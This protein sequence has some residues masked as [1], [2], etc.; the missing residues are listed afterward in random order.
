MC[1]QDFSD[2]GTTAVRQ[3]R[4][5]LHSF[6]F[7]QEWDIQYFLVRMTHYYSD[8]SVMDPKGR[9]NMVIFAKL[10]PVAQATPG[11]T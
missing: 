5:S 6:L 8:M 2:N 10:P 9:L 3:P 4:L 1:H 11:A 7:S